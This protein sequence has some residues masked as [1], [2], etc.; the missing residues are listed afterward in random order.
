M[1]ERM[2][3][4]TRNNQCLGCVCELK[5]SVSINFKGENLLGILGN[6]E[7]VDIITKLILLD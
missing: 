7:F 2:S 5:A 3:V 6:S 1:C 4:K